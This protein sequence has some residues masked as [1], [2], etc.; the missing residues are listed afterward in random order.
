MLLWKSGRLGLV[1]YAVDR[2]HRVFAGLPQLHVV[3]LVEVPHDCWFTE[4]SKTGD[5]E[6]KMRRRLNKRKTE[7]GERPI[8]DVWDQV[9]ARDWFVKLNASRPRGLPCGNRK[10]QVENVDM[11]SKTSEEAVQKM[12]RIKASSRVR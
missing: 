3:C 12:C 7:F 4:G 8:V 2:D 11:E 6:S 10:G 5:G 9:E 1:R